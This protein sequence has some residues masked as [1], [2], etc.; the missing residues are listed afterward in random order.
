MSP[1]VVFFCSL[2]MAHVF[3]LPVTGKQVR[4]VRFQRMEMAS[5]DSFLDSGENAF[6]ELSQWTLCVRVRLFHLTRLNTI[7]SYT[8]GEHYQEIMLG[9][10]WPQSNLRLECCKYEGFMEMAVPLRLYTW[11]QLCLSADMAKDVQYMIFDGQVHQQL[12]RRPGVTREKLYRVRG[13][14]RFYLGNNY[15]PASELMVIE[16]FHGDLADFKFYDVA[17]SVENLKA[18]AA[19]QPMNDLPTPLYEFD[20][21]MTNLMPNGDINIYQM[22]LGDICTKTPDLNMIIPEKINFD[23]SLTMCGFFTGGI[24]VPNNDEESVAIYDKYDDFNNY[25]ADSW[26]TSFW[27]GLRANLTSRWWT[28]VSNGKPLTWADFATG[29]KYPTE[30]YRCMAFGSINFKYKWCASPCDILQ[31]PICNFTSIP[32]LH[33]RGLCELSQFDRYYYPY[34]Y[35]NKKP[36]LEGLFLSRMTWINDTWVIKSRLENEVEA[37]MSSRNADDYPFGLHTWNVQGDTCTQEQV[38][39][40][41][42]SCEPSDFTCSDGSCIK[43]IKRCDQEVD[44]PDN[45]DELNCDVIKIP[46]GYSAQ[47]A[48]PAVD[49]PQ[50]SLHISLD[51]T[52]IRDFNILGFMVAVDIIQSIK[53]KDAR[54][55]LRNLRQGDFPNEAKS[56]DKLW[57]PDIL[58]KDGTYSPTDLQIRRVRMLV[59]RDANSLPDDDSNYSEDELYRGMNNT[60]KLEQQYTVSAMCQ[61]LLHA[62]PFDSQKCSIVYSIPDQSVGKIL[63]LQEEVKFTGERRLLEYELV[64]ETLT[65]HGNMSAAV[66]LRLVFQNQYGYYIGNAVVPSLLMATIC[67]LTFF[68]DLDDFTDRIMVSLTSLLVLAALFTQTSQSIPK[69]A[70]LKLIDIWYVTLIIA[71]FLIIVMLVVIENHRLHESITGDSSSRVFHN[72]HKITPVES[73]GHL[74]PAKDFDDKKN[75]SSTARKMNTISK[76]SFPVL[77]TIGCFCWILLHLQ[78]APTSHGIYA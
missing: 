56:F 15:N 18:F 11:H 62:Y 69:T 55:I 63:L 77:A 49:S 67:Y 75:G 26:G 25:C 9:F 31:C 53:W 70:Y 50:L 54:L 10:D 61:F 6:P 71:D 37:R 1:G 24:I 5:N 28:K 3:P 58:V 34:D 7:L 45:T 21:N 14:G 22:D 74:T 60:V 32:Q 44:C 13:G 68:F 20:V 78:A 57:L 59:R 42:T 46:E 39:L 41:L 17:L 27:L 4:V 12:I 72:T 66:Q 23:T 73:A 65:A 29:W 47:L 43:K 30:E 36:V 35:Y 48:P 40:L 2:V 33:L 76:W 51:I 16:T 8:T 52:S 38:Q 19:C 64:N